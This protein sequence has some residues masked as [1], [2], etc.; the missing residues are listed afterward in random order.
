MGGPMTLA[1]DITNPRQ[2]TFLWEA[3]N[4]SD[5]TAMGYTVGRPVI[6]NVYDTGDPDGTQDHWVAL[7][8]G[9]QAVPWSSTTS[10]VNYWE[11]AEPSLYMWAI[12]GD[13]WGDD[14]R[15]YDM[16][17]INAGTDFFDWTGAYDG[18]NWGTADMSELTTDADTDRIEHAYISASIA[19]VDVDSDG[20]HDVLYFPV[21]TSY[22]PRDQGGPGPGSVVVPGSTFVYKA[23]LNTATPDDP[24]WVRWYDP[25]DG[26]TDQGFTNGIGARPTVFYS[27]TTAWR[28]DGTLGIFWGSGTPFDRETVTTQGYFFAMFDPE[29]TSV[30]TTANSILCDGHQGYYPLDY[31][32]GLTSPPVVYAGV[33]YF[34]T[35]TPNADRCEAGVGKVYGLRF[36]DC[37]PGIDTN[38]DGAA[39]AA[40]DPAVASEGYVSGVTVTSQ[41]RVYYAD[42]NPDAGEDRLHSIEAATDPFLGTAAIAWMQV[43]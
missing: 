43:M 35:Y 31:G 28:Q 38:G 24:T 2:P 17:G 15:V 26:T 3:M 12:G 14:D 20:D 18:A 27:A 13:V 30:S 11:A 39:D 33:V 4:N 9:G 21:T 42:A 23:V 40:D 10:G 36:D 37:S 22:T 8:G 1:L 6:M 32:E 34:S 16:A 19:A 5:Y 7:W 25:M 41:G 29:P